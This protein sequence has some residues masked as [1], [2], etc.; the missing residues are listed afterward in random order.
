[1]TTHAL[2]V[3]GVV[4]FVLAAIWPMLPASVQG[5]KINLVA[6]GLALEFGTGF[7]G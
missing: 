2:R 6:L 4:C 5:L 7:A 1:M 3:A